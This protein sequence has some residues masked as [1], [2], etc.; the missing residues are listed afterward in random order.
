MDRAVRMPTDGVV[1][2][3]DGTRLLLP[4]ESV[5]VHG[6]IPGAVAIARAVCDAMGAAGVHLAPFAI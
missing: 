3:V 1:V 6:D 2:A 5:C 4:V